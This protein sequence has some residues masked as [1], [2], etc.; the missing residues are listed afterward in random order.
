MQWPLYLVNKPGFVTPTFIDWLI[1][2]NNRSKKISYKMFSSMRDERSANWTLSAFYFPSTDYCNYFYLPILLLV[3]NDIFITEFGT[4]FDHPNIKYMWSPKCLP[5]STSLCV[6]S[7]KNELD[8]M[9]FS[10]LG[11]CSNFFLNRINYGGL[12]F[13]TITTT[14]HVQLN[15]SNFVE[16]IKVTHLSESF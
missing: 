14:T 4:L 5:I 12:S 10:Y 2:K 8:F 11:K 1:N 15:W 6:T 3:M 9:N 13:K 7:A 16:K